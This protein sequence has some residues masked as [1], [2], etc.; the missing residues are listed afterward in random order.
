MRGLAQGGQE[1]RRAVLLRRWPPFASGLRDRG[2]AWSQRG[3]LRIGAWGPRF[4]GGVSNWSGM[5]CWGWCVEVARSKGQ[6]G[7]GRRGPPPFLHADLRWR[8]KPAECAQSQK[9]RRDTDT[10]TRLLECAHRRE[11]KLVGEFRNERSDK[12]WWK[13][14]LVDLCWAPGEAVHNT[15]HVFVISLCVSL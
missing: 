14:V 11:A 6:L 5:R 2:W 8:V 10:S 3:P 15:P 13:S 7:R 12:F 4:C 9:T 1:D